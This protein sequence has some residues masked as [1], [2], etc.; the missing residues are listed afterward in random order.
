[1]QYIQTI[2]LHPQ[3]QTC[4]K[5]LLEAEEDRIYCHHDI[6][7]LL[8]VARIAYIR[9]L[10]T[11]AG[12]SKRVIYA[13]ALLHDIGKAAQYEDGTPHEVIGAGIAY[14][15]L[16]DICRRYPDAFL[17]IEVNE[18]VRAVYEHRRCPEGSSRLGI[19]LYAAD[20]DSRVCFACD[21]QKTCSWSDE[22]KNMAIT[23]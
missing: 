22:R 1:M 13:A 21:A 12:F 20:K 6:T 4:Y 14:D 19:L 18:I 11:N 10:E 3:F 9:N 15:I 2:W 17:P 23:I 8:D 7:H 16:Q 5:K